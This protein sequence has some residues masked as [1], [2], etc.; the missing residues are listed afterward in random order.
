VDQW[1]GLKSE[2][3]KGTKKKAKA[4]IL[5]TTAQESR[6]FLYPMLQNYYCSSTIE[7]LEW[8]QSNDCD[9]AREPSL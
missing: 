1:L 2:G 8:Y 6:E 3:C 9:E 5:D 4:K 7:K